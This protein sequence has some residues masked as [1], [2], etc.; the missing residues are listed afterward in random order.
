MKRRTWSVV[1]GVGLAGLTTGCADARPR[2][3]MLEQQRV[4]LVKQ[5]KAMQLELASAHRAHAE[6]DAKLR[7]ADTEIQRLRARLAEREAAGA[8]DSA[9]PGWTAVPGGAMI[10]IPGSVLFAPGKVTIRDDAMRALDALA[11]AI[12]G[13]YQ[14]KDIL[15]YGHTDDTPIRRSGWADNWQLSTER[16]LAVVRALRERDVSPEQ[17]VACGCG[18]FR[19]VFDNNTDAN[20]AHNRRVEIF[21]LTAQPRSGRP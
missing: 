14:D 12:N 16:A 15:V 11:S 1:C 20:R 8:P 7:A 6:R 3:A 5:V 18:A 4:D 10:A 17:L 19:P 21:A 2:I 13:T 9:A